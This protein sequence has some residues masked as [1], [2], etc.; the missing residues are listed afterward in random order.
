M[1]KTPIDTQVAFLR[2]RLRWYGWASLSR[3][4]NFDPVK[5]LLIVSSPRGGS[6]WLMELIA[7]MPGTAV[8]WE[9]LHPK[10][11]RS[12]RVAALHNAWRQ[13]IPE[14]ANW[15]EARQAFDLILRGRVMNDWTGSQSSVAG[16]IAAKQ[17]VVK[18]C[19]AHTM[20][21][22]LI[23]N[24]RFKYAPIYLVRHP[25][26]VVASQMRERGWEH[27][28]S[29]FVIPDA[30]YNEFY[31]KH[32][33]FLQRL[34]TEEEIRVA[35]WCLCNQYLLRHGG[36]NKSWI[37][38]YYEHLLSEPRKEIKRI[39]ERW[40][41][42]VPANISAQIRKPSKTTNR[43]TAVKGVE[44]QLSKWR[45]YFDTDQIDRMMNVLRYFKVECYGLDTFPRGSGNARREPGLTEAAE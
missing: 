4:N 32:H 40:R 45:S 42:K 26:A 8:L 14:G 27:G 2:N 12:E 33:E 3:L 22:W 41:L 37:T 18:F 36:N 10:A 44:R 16:F 25:F 30:R 20:L 29:S 23:S 6:S 5:D 7:T 19:R 21:P 17:L 13:H 28:K 39:F 31:G 24:F 15:K 11:V 1:V 43:F 35:N 9:P 38:V 34:S